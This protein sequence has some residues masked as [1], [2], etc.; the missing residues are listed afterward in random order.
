[1]LT[2]RL[3]IVQVLLAKLVSFE[4]F[5]IPEIKYSLSNTGFVGS[6]C[7]GLLPGTCL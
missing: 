7:L 1:M 4:G 6:C 2:S 3:F 5:I